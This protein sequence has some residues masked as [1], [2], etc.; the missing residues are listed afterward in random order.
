MVVS[1][2]EEAD[3]EDPGDICHPCGLDLRGRR[4]RG[5]G[6]AR[7]GVTVDV[8]PVTA[9]HELQDYEAIV[10]GSAIRMGR[11]QPEAVEFVTTNRETLSHIPTATLW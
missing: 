5:R 11:W 7:G 10:V 9:V 8:R 3:E 4:A 1:D 2:K 6:A